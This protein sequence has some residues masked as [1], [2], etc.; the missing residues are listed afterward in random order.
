MKNNLS[1][2]L[3]ALALVFCEAAMAVGQFSY[4]AS[5]F[6]YQ[7]GQFGYRALGQP[8]APPPSY[9]N[10][11]LPTSAIGRFQ[12]PGL[13]NGPNGF[14]PLWQPPYLGAITPA[15]APLPAAQLTVSPQ[16]PVGGVPVVPPPGAATP[17]VQIGPPPQ[18]PPPGSVR[19]AALPGQGAGVPSVA[20]TGRTWNYSTGQSAGRA[21]FARAEPYVRS[22]ELSA[23]LTRLARNRGMLVGPA[24]NVY[25]GGDVAVVQGVVRTAADRAVL[26]NVLG[27]EPDVSRIDDRLVVQGYGSRP[28][29]A[30]TVNVRRSVQGY[31]AIVMPAN[32]P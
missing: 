31:Q 9:F 24:I 23:R 28:A 25:L 5:Q 1:I 8:L 4:Q 15:I 29:N 16:S 3:A 20:A 17:A 13:L 27:L 22:P 11:G 7:A 10:G 18:L 26:R 32:G 21:A 12:T 30:A 2:L 14:V 6:S 19:P